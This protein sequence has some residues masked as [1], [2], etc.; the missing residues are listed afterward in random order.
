MEG[1]KKTRMLSVTDEI[2]RSSASRTEH[3][4]GDI[5]DQKDEDIF[6]VFA[7]TDGTFYAETLDGHR[8]MYQAVRVDKIYLDGDAIR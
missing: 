4:A 3:P 1:L 7:G 8:V 5:P 2:V 6:D